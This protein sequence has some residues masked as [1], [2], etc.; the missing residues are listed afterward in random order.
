MIFSRHY[1]NTENPCFYLSYPTVSFPAV[2]SGLESCPSLL[3]TSVFCYLLSSLALALSILCCCYHWVRDDEDLPHAI[4]CMAYCL[5]LLFI[6]TSVAGTTSVFTH[7]DSISNG[8]VFDWESK[9]V[10]DCGMT[11][12]PYGIMILSFFLG[13]FFLVM[14]Y[15]A[16]ILALGATS[17]IKW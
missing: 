4:F 12:L 11:Y 17:D 9:K 6:F 3:G 13:A 14:S 7:Y 15:V 2:F 10:L 5:L 1:H 8:T 16:C